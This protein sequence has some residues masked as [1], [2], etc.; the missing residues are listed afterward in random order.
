MQFSSAL[1]S[2]QRSMLGEDDKVGYV[3][4]TVRHLTFF[5][6]FSKYGIH[7]CFLPL[8]YAW[9]SYGS[10]GR[11]DDDIYKMLN[12]TAVSNAHFSVYVI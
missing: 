9:L 11:S 4:H 8:I 1:S 2:I 6:A 12:V 3:I 7:N 5:Q 10:M